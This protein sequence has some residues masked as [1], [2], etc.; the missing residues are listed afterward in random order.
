MHRAIYAAHPGLNAVIE[1]A[2]LGATAFSVTGTP[3]ESRT[4]PESFLLLREVGGVPYDLA[5]TDPE[6]V[7]T[8]V[9]PE[10]PTALLQNR[11]ILVVGRS[12][13]EAFDRLEVLEANAQSVICARRLGGFTALSDE[14]VEELREVFLRPRDRLGPR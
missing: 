4:I 13:L 6:R 8:I 7:A 12:L 3:M 1:A 11:G 2:P 10:Q 5:R 9:C 14:A